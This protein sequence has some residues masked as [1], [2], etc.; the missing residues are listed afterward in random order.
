MRYAC[1]IILVICLIALTAVPASAALRCDICK[2]EI[3]GKYVTGPDHTTYCWDCYTKYPSCTVCG[4]IY[5]SL[6]DVDGK[7]I[8]RDCYSKL[9]KCDICGKALLGEYVTYPELKMNVCGDCERTAPRCDACGRPAKRLNRVG[10]AMLCNDCAPKTNRCYSCGDALLD[11]YKYFENDE[12]KK[13]C[14][15]C[16]SKYPKCAN[17]G[18]PSG[19]RGTRL[20]D[21]RYLCQD[22]RAEA[23]FDPALITPV[24]LRVLKFLEHGMTMEIEHN[25]NYAVQDEKFLE[26]KSKGMSKDINGMF[27][28][29]G[30][31]YNVYVLYGLRKKDLIWVLAH[32]ITHA[33]QAE[34]CS[35]RLTD[36]EREGFAQWIAYKTALNFGYRQYSENMR[37][38]D[39]I[40]S[41]GLNRMIDIEKKGGFRAVFDY[42]KSK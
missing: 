17:C 15:K 20:D 27:Y 1:N 35:D 36:E 37:E 18:A 9:K 41:T 38:G 24:K 32:E 10:N 40:Y 3:T 16:V 5:K 19:P 42:I 2:K 26:K 23:I 6:I 31:D 12:S 14:Q 28:R 4:K 39:S 22:C 11:N 25:I 34:N 7:K 8:C 21:G 29:K 13:Y 30:N 33:W